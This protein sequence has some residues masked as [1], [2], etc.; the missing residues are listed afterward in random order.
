MQIKN[1][2]LDLGGVI[3][4]ISYEAAANA[5]K[6]L[7]IK[8]FDEL[9]SQKKQDH[10]FDNYE[11]GNISDE[12]FRNEIKK[13]IPHPVGDAQIDD[14]WNSMLFSIPTKRV[15]FLKELKEKYRLFLLSNTNCIHI[16][17]FTEIVNRDF[18]KNILPDLFE[19]IYFSCKIN[20]R[21]PDTEIFNYVMN[22]NH[23]KKE[24]TIFIDDSI[25]HVEGG[26]R[27]GLTSY[28][29]DLSKNTLENFLP[30][31]LLTVN[32]LVPPK[33]GKP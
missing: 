11:T 29:L 32:L 7:G 18:G 28:H 13:N 27:A 19:K 26:K 10:F 9:Y 31:I 33:A 2:I 16:N 17:A 1:I 25:Q 6:K 4:D 24:E 15:A 3:I 5:F 21:K 23:L 12:K 8:N 14:A 22:E 20:M 30:E